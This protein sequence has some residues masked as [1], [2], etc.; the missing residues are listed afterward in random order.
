MRRAFT[1]IELLIVVAIIAI[2]AAIA[3][4]NFLEAQTRAKI[5]TVLSDFR[6]LRTGMESYRIDF[7]KYPVDYNYWWSGS[8]GNINGV[9][10]DFGTWTQLTTPVAYLTSV[11]YTPFV[12]KNYHHNPFGPKEVYIYGGGPVKAANDSSDIWERQ[13]GVDFLVQCV[14]PDQFADYQWD[15][16][17]LFSLER[18]YDTRLIYDA[19]NGT[20]SSGDILMSNKRT[21]GGK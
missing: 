9:A 1:L 8:P 19:T 15:T 2:L 18:G 20:I 7:S 11:L 21:Y 17:S 4:P 14:G 13:T 3:V 5:A 16:P 12:A 10:N 6:T